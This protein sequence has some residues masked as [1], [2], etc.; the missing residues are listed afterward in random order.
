MISVIIPTYNRFNTLCRAIES[1]L[2]QTYTNF[3]I[4]VVNDCSTD[5]EYYSGKLELYDK[6]K[7]INLK[8][9]QKIKYN[10]LAAQGKTREEGMKIADPKCEWFAFLDDDDYFEKNKLEYQLNE[11]GKNPG[12]LFCATNMYKFYDSGEKELYHNI[13][14]PKIFDL[15]L[16]ETC[17]YINNS[18]VLIHKSICDKVGDFTIGLYE[19]YVYWKKAL[20]YTKCLYLHEGLVYYSCET[21]N[22]Y[23]IYKT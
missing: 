22:K 20:V 16:I 11:L 23:Y 18:S 7:V 3:E 13:N 8:I 5:P 1:V 10:T 4:I 12:I 21:R 9:N 2:A 15:K 6:T 17:N 14:L 19:D